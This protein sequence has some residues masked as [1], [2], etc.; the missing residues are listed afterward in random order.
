VLLLGNALSLDT[1]VGATLLWH[2]WCVFVKGMVEKKNVSVS[3]FS[4]ITHTPSETP[5]P[6]CTRS[7]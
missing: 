3:V 7:N 6:E 4:K 5:C 2:G 1:L